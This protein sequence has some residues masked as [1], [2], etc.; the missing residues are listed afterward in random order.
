[1]PATRCAVSVAMSVSA[2]VPRAA[3]ACQSPFP[4]IAD[5]APKPAQ[6]PPLMKRQKRDCHRSGGSPLQA[7]TKFFRCDADF[8]RDAMRSAYGEGTYSKRLMNE[9]LFWS[10]ASGGNV[11]TW[12]YLS[13]KE[14]C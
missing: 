12:P 13:S 7:V 8:C 4:R 2:I 10:S 1:L 5:V 14:K 3:S 9:A 6:I 11:R